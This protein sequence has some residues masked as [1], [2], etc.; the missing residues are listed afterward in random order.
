MSKIVIIR[1]NAD[2]VENIHNTHLLIGESNFSEERLDNI[3]KIFGSCLYQTELIGCSNF[4][5]LHLNMVGVNLVMFPVAAGLIFVP[6]RR[7]FR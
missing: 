7:M 2:K 1:N 3:D 5:T 6:G 4:E